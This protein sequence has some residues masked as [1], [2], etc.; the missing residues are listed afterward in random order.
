MPASGT[1][2]FMLSIPP[3][4]WSS[5]IDVSCSS[6]AC[7]SCYMSSYSVTL[8]LFLSSL[9]L[10]RLYV[11]H[12]FSNITGS[13]A[14]CVV[15]SLL[16]D[17]LRRLCESHSIPSNLVVSSFG[18]IF[19]HF[20]HYE[21]H[22]LNWPIHVSSISLRTNGENN[23]F[24]VYSEFLMDIFHNTASDNPAFYHSMNNESKTNSNRYSY[25][26]YNWNNVRCNHRQHYVQFFL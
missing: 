16:S 23:I 8:H 14:I 13:I 21:R 3:F 11:V 9:F 19:S 12:N 15:S 22:L 24:H 26:I 10:L 17:N 18:N 25:E 4:P 5:C 7:F 1:L 6:L 20:H 2:A